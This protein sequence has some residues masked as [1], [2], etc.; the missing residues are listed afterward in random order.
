[1]LKRAV[2]V[3]CVS[4]ALFVIDRLAK[5]AFFGFSGVCNEGISF[6]F[7]EGW[8]F[9]LMAV[10]LLLFFGFLFSLRE[11]WGE[12]YFLFGLGLF[13][14]GAV[15]N[16]LDRIYYGC[17]RDVFDFFGWFVFNISDGLLFFGAIFIVWSVLVRDHR[18]SE[19][20]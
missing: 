11:L 1:M 8:G 3:F 17:V 2:F 12:G 4:T 18:E 6:G 5:S 10:G 16:I 9:V 14:S 13:L 7:F 20:I 15:S 19:S